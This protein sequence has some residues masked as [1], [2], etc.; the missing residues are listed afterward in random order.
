MRDALP[1]TVHS[2][3]SAIVNL[4]SKHNSGTHW[5][6]YI[7][8]KNIVWYFDSFGDLKPPRELAT[9]FGPTAEIFYNNEPY[10]TFS[11]VNCGHL[12]L[13]FLHNQSCR[14]SS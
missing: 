4:D 8:N 13:S 2:N 6:A 7:K 10:Q 1:Q 14:R 3:E 12:C 5:V 11:Q 9:Y